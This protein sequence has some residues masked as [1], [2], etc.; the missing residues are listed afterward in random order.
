MDL[1]LGVRVCM[2]VCLC[3]LY[4]AAILEFLLIFC[5]PLLFDVIVIPVSAVITTAPVCG[6]VS[7]RRSRR[8]VRACP[9]CIQRLTHSVYSCRVTVCTRS[10]WLCSVSRKWSK[11]N[12][13]GSSSS[14]WSHSYA[15]REKVGG[16]MC[17]K[18]PCW[19]KS[20]LGFR[21]ND[22]HTHS[23]HRWL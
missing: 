2:W 23:T 6:F 10:L 15:Q 13:R 16:V 22:E 8:Q 21:W 17:E 11:R 3:V 9:V 12:T 1:N 14:Y 18:G 19:F 4:F 20:W 5:S 7:D